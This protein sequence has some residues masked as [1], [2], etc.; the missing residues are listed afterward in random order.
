MTALIVTLLL[1]SFNTDAAVWRNRDINS[2]PGSKFSGKPLPAI[3]FGRAKANV[4]AFIAF[5][6]LPNL[7]KLIQIPNANRI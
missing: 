7:G 2:E 5:K 1:L 6:E 4:I 3:F